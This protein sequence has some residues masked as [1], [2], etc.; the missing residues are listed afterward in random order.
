MLLGEMPIIRI[1]EEIHEDFKQ[2][3]CDKIAL[4]TSRVIDNMSYNE[5]S[6]K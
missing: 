6:T 1:T 5:F 2:R 4:N 3:I